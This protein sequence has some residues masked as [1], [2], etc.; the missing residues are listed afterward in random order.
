MASLS[1]GT[2]FLKVNSNKE[3]IKTFQ[4]IKANY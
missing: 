1:E 2:Y 3:S 4:I